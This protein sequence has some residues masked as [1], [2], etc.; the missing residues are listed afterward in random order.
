MRISKIKLS[1]FKSF[2]DPTTLLLPENLTGIV[3][4]NGC[5]KSN[6]IDA[7]L[8]VMGESSAKHLR[9][10]S[11]TDVI[12][13]G[14][15]TRKPVGQA[16]VEIIFDNSD[17]SI[18]GQYAGFGEISIKR[19]LNR[20]GGSH[21]LLN[22]TRCRRRDIT[23]LFLGTGLGSRSYS[24]IEQGMISRV[25]E[26]KPEELRG[27]LEEAAGISK[28]KERRRDTENR[29]RHS[30]DNIAR[31][32]DIRDELEKQINRLQRQAKAAERYKTLKQEE[33]QLQAQLLALQIDALKHEGERREGEAREREN[34]V[35]AVMA[36][37]RSVENTIEKQRDEQVTLNEHFNEVQGRYYGIGAEISRQEQ[38]IQHIRDGHEGLQRDLAQAGANLETA[39]EHAVSDREALGVVEQELRQIQPRHQALLAKE[40]EAMEALQ[41][42]EQ[43]QRDWQPQW[44]EYHHAYTQA[45]RDEHGVQTRIS[46]LDGTI[47][48]VEQQLAKLQQEL[49]ETR[50]PALEQNLELLRQR[51]REQQQVYDQLQERHAERQRQMREVRQQLHQHSQR[52]D[53]TRTRQQTLKGR[54]SSLEALQQGALG[55]QQQDLRAWLGKHALEQLPRLAQL[56]EAEPGWEHALEQVLGRQLE[57]LCVADLEQIGAIIEDLEG[58]H[59]SVLAQEA[60]GAALPMRAPA[61]ALADKL[62][63]RWPVATWLQGIYAVDDRAQALALL[64]RL[65]RHESVVT[66]QGLRLG[67]GW[68][69]SGTWS[70]EKTGVLER[71]REIRELSTAFARTQDQLEQQTTVLEADQARLQALE[72]EL[73]ELEQQLHRAQELL[74][75]TQ[76]EQAAAESRLDQ[77]RQRNERIDSEQQ[78]LRSRLRA[79]RQEL[80]TARESLQHLRQRLDGLSGERERLGLEREGLERNLEAR[81]ATLRDLREQTRQ[82]A[83]RQG[84]LETRRGSLQQALERNAALTEQLRQR[85]K[86]LEQRCEEVLAPL[87]E[88]ESQLEQSL[89]RRVGIETE[90]RQ[91]REA[92]HAREALL[93]DLDHQRSELE[94]RIQQRRDALEAARVAAQETRVRL[95]TLSEQLQAMDYPLEDLLRELADE[96]DAGVELWQQRIDR[97]NGR[98]HR[99]GPIN[100]AAI[101]EFEQ[102]SERK[103]YLDRQ[104]DDLC[105]AL[106]TLESAIRKID[107]ETRARFKE[108][109][110]KVNNGL[111]RMFPRLFGGGHAQLE[112]TGEDLLDTGV[113]VMA[114]PPGKRNSSIHLLSGGEKALT[115]VAF[116]F[117]IFQLNPAPFCLLDEVDAPL[118]DANV[119]R[120]CDMIREMSQDVQF[121]YI[122]HNKLT[123]EISQQLIGVTMN[124]PGVSRLVSV[125]MEAAVELAATA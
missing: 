72:T 5:G 79:A 66:R 11:M 38:S 28:Y 82:T 61:T 117:A 96:E 100:L 31:I 9:G 122:T 13:N 70:E 88:L 37:L 4:P 49:E 91:A 113:T 52:L 107:S 97:L 56:L 109:Y 104:H 62:K 48:Q 39:E 121:M 115:A 116:V 32:N 120:L 27:F 44:D 18:G 59:L 17:A 106:Q 50:T 103:A 86:A 58:G 89:S 54:L 22:G 119:G 94:Q 76:A 3:G 34:A 69:E 36:E 29:I 10:D 63:C 102:E 92:V 45:S 95:Q 123:M 47:V 21:Y 105:E 73:D 75:Q 20:E 2:V 85:R 83:I 64:P 25:I 99:L 14:S 35:E 51:L 125:N 68:L 98:I 26:A 101:S 87:P 60:P 74:R 84:S 8:W 12:F 7:L 46:S 1:G 40:Q 41:A 112:L 30:R 15:N 23:N 19:V 6:I 111:Q 110:D 33:R 42:A 78:G 67:P 24:V 124:E 55:Q 118:D 93:R 71:E 65:Q 81:R 114:H 53:E 77:V 80:A 90:L 57:A 108:T 16:M 43:A